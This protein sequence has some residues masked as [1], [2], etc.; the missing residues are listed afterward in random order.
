[1]AR[2]PFTWPGNARVAF[3]LGIAFEAWDRS[4]PTRGGALQSP[5]PKDALCKRDYSTESFREFGPKVGIRRL[6]ALCD[7]YDLKASMPLNGLTCLYY[8]ELVKYAHGRGHEM[9]AHGW[10]QGEFLYMLTREQ[11][12]ENIFNTVEAIAKTTGEKPTGWSSPGVRSTDNTPE[13][14]VEA[15]LQY[16]CD[17][18][19]EEMPYPLEVNG[20]LLIEFPHQYTINDNRTLHGMT[21]HE[22]FEKFKDEFDYRYK[23]GRES[24]TMMNVITH[25]YISSRIPM[26]D[27]FERI[28]AYAKSHD[29]VWFARRGD[30]AAWARKYYGGS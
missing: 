1:M 8:P 13:L 17:Y 12:R 19:D 9:V 3:V 11:E 24:P 16:H 22:F 7:K 10:D 2:E 25:G 21:R 15:G 5:L 6:L 14:I 4:K 20:K 26:I 30:V 18:H 23:I 29:E 28:I 27:T